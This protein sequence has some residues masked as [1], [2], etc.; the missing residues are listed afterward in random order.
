ML[1]L[2]I[3]SFFIFY[4]QEYIGNV[5]CKEALLTFLD[6]AKDP[7][8]DQPDYEAFRNILKTELEKHKNEPNYHK[9]DWQ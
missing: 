1:H 6:M 8:N 2:N 4:S 3:I 9:F 7:K 5:E